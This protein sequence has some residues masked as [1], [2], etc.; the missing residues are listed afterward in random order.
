MNDN[1]N[2]KSCEA[3]ADEAL[4]AITGGGRKEYVRPTVTCPECNQPKER[5]V[6]CRDPK[7]PTKHKSMCADCARDLG[8]V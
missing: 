6:I 3:L 4:D 1:V 2:K 5:L 7:D 8:Y